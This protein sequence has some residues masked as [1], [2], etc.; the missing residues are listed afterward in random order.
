MLLLY[1]HTDKEIILLL[2]DTTGTVERV[3]MYGA[4]RRDRKLKKKRK[5]KK[6]QCLVSFHLWLCGF[7][8]LYLAQ[9]GKEWW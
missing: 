7:F 5:K 9:F 6:V 2:G 4:V 1:E 8:F 3:L